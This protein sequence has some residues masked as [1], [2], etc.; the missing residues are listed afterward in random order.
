MDTCATCGAALTQGVAH[1]CAAPPANNPPAP[2]A[3]N[4]PAD[5]P[6]PALQLSAD[7]QRRL[8]SNPD[9]LRAL[10]G[11]P[12]RPEGEQQAAQQF[13]LST[14][15]LTMLASGGFLQQLLGIGG[16]QA[17]EQRQVVD[18]TRRPAAT[19]QVVEQPAYRFDR[20]GNLTA[21][22]F[23]FSSDVIAGLQG[24]KAA[25][26]RATSFVSEQFQR[27][28][29]V[30]Q[31]DVSTLSP[32]RQR[33]DL[34]VDQKEFAYPIWNAI[35][36][37]TIPDATPFV[38]PKFSTSSGLVANHTE[39]TE[40]SLGAFQATSQTITPSPVSGKIKISREAWDQG[41][42]PQ[43][44]GLI[45][46][47]MTRAWFE[48][49]ESA[50]VTML[51]GLAPTTITITTAAADAALEA[52]ITSQLA[53]LQYV[54]GGFTMRDFFVQVDLYKALIAAKDSNGRKLFP[55]INAQN[56]TGTTS[57]F[58][59]DILVAGLRGRPAW[60]LA[61]TSVNSSNS[62]LFDRG[63]VS[64]WA[65]APNRLSFEQLEVANVY[66]GLWGYKAMACTDLTGVRRLA[67]DPV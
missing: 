59:A 49:L 57:E 61:A 18:A 16:Q 53:P 52:S 19:T 15:Q 43:L 47:Q 17:P 65:T 28:E 8:F 9:V 34:Y 3:S 40:P 62:Y 32:P 36:K 41:G 31:S 35:E 42:N 66:I 4:P 25:L 11:V 39:G 5:P 37:G 55:I 54:R 60:A 7:Q 30:I 64:G 29:F 24:D 23:D 14:E 38:L 67:Y 45:W 26:E 56:A 6:A 63:N 2:P 50:A 13:S 21:G 12:Q 22:K 48:A 10:M 20:K 51:E 46:R 27:E 1:T 33:P 58:F 44:S